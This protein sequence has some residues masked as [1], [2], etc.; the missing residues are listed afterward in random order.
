MIISITKNN[1]TF[2]AYKEISITRN[3]IIDIYELINFKSPFGYDVKSH[4]FIC[5]KGTK[6]NFKDTCEND[7]NLI[8]ISEE[9]INNI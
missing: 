9:L 2:Q 7:I 5:S 1:R 8:K 3:I 4:K 6:F